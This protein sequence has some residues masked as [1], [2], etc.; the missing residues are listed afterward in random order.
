MKLR[1]LACLLCL[2]PIAGPAAA[3]GFSPAQR[4]EIIAI[5]R[6]ALKTDPSI[7]RDAVA[8]LTADDSQKQ[9][10]AAH[11]AISAAGAELTAK[12][13]DPVA[14]NPSGDVTIVE[15]FD[16]R[17]PYCK[18]LEPT[19]DKLLKQDH[20]VRLVYKDLPILGPASVLGT[21]ALLAA[22][23]QETK[24]PGAYIKLREALMLGGGDVNK[25]TIH[26]AAQRLGLDWERLQKDMD[27]ADV[28]TR[29]DAN[30]KLAHE[31]GIEGTP[32]MVIGKDLVPGAVDFAELDDA[33][34][35]ARKQP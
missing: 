22:Q 32:A 21:K 24:V 16:V 19:M 15:F 10:A 9:E 1:I 31:L 8:A 6:E 35:K 18:R 26:A 30:L 27:S 7:L 14:G 34:K 4:D 29:I 12:S 20:G 33:V 13:S 5:V 3:Q 17:C 2:A 25:E 28:Q 11:A 23:L